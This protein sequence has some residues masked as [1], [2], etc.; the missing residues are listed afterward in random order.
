MDMDTDLLVF[1]CRWGIVHTEKFWRENAK[2]VENNDFKLLKM[3]IALLRSDDEVR[4]PVPRD[5]TIILTLYA[6]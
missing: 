4:C 5:I 3:L 6:W 1:L 2:F